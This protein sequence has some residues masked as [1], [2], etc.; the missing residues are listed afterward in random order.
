LLI[1]HDMGLVLSVCDHVLV[2]DFGN[3]IAEGPPA[4]IRANPAV[5]EAYLGSQEAARHE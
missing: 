2:L 3:L 1:D 4:Q 5:I